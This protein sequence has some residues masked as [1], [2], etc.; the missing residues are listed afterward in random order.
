MTF[1]EAAIHGPFVQRDL[2]GGLQIPLGE[3]F[4]QVAVGFNVFGPIQRFV[5]G[6]GGEK[7]NRHVAVLLNAPGRFNAVHRPVDTH[8][9]EDEI[10]GR[11]G[12]RSAGFF[13]AGG[14]AHHVVAQTLQNAL[15]IDGDDLLVF[16]N[17]DLDR[18]FWH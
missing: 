13:A 4:D 9:H 14:R 1:A 11:F 16:D 3:W 6:V 2:D 17:E 7:H 10:G 8:V 12:G 5:V 15:D 18:L